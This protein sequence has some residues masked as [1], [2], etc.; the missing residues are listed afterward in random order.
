MSQPYLW[1]SQRSS[2]VVGEAAEPDAEVEDSDDEEE[3]SGFRQGGKEL[4][5]DLKVS[6]GPVLCI[7][8]A[9]AELASNNHS[10][11]HAIHRSMH[12]IAGTLFTKSQDVLIFVVDCTNPEMFT[13]PPGESESAVVTALK[14][15]AEVVEDKSMKSPSDRVSLVF[16]GT[17]SFLASEGFVQP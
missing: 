11:S 16:Y 2:G 12:L 5:E 15:F 7:A 13:P 4:F 10:I 8:P 1:Q 3:E 14:C 6:A 17:V 9:T